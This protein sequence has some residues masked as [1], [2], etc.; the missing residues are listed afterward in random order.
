MSEWGRFKIGTLIRFCPDR[1]EPL[2]REEK[3]LGIVTKLAE[4]TFTIEYFD[5][6]VYQY[7]CDDDVSTLI[8]LSE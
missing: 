4:H 7:D 8:I 2:Y 6:L 3:Y 1:H 5:G